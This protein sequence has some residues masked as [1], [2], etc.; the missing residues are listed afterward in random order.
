MPIS[1]PQMLFGHSQIDPEIS[2]FSQLTGQETMSVKLYNL[3]NSTCSQKARI[4]LAEKGVPF[5]DIQIDLKRN[6]QYEDWY[7]KLNPNGVVPTLVHDGV[8]VIDSTVICEYV[9]DAFPTP[10]MTPP[11]A[12]DRA[13]MRAWRQYS[14]EVSTPSIRIPSFNAYIVPAWGSNEWLANRKRSSPLRKAQ[15]NRLTSDG[16][17]IEDVVAAMERLTQCIRRMEAQLSAGGPWLLGEQYT[18]MDVLL[19]PTIVRIHDIGLDFMFADAPAVRGWYDRVQ[20]RPS[21]AAAYYEGSRMPPLRQLTPEIDAYRNR[22]PEPRD[23]SVVG[24]SA[25]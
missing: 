6:E 14:D 20:K 11:T 10:A 25:S 7:L 8:A 12:A 17:P 4:I 3:N 9:D 24:K 15:F 13:K 5:E 16:Y 1:A 21:F 18:I 2:E 19:T 22:N 23:A